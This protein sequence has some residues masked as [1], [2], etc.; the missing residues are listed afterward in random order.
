[1]SFQFTLQKVMQVREREKNQGQAEYQKA[2][3]QF[4]KVATKLYELLKK[5][6]SLEE[7]ARKQIS[8]GTSIYELQQN[9]NEMMRLQQ[10]IQLHQRETQRARDKMSMKEQDFLQKAIECKKYEKMKQLK[11]N[12]FIEEEKRKE[13]VQ[14]DE[15]SIQLFAKR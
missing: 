15:I 11:E 4:E 2:I 7:R 14:M 13:A 8:V 10:E 9:Q 6:E 12:E 5:K 3:D 1:M